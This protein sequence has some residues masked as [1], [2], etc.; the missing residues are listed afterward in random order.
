MSTH[1]YNP[2][3]RS[4]ENNIQFVFISKGKTTI[5]KAIEYA[6]VNSLGTK[7]VFN[8]GFGDYDPVTK[9]TR[10]DILSNNDDSYKVFNTVL[11]S[12]PVFFNKYPDA[13]LMVEGSDSKPEF[14]K[15]CKQNLCNKRCR[16][17]EGCK[18][19]NRRIKLYTNYVSKN[20]DILSR[21]YKFY[22]GINNQN[23]ELDI[24]DFEPNNNY[25]VVFVIKAK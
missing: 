15:A 7:N 20:W 3:I 25:Q 10:D 1:A 12:I 5:F 9:V 16:T 6:F 8:L 13:L 24:V 11:N 23:N 22:G 21:E 14:A 18:N 19:K 17:A 2:E 4:S